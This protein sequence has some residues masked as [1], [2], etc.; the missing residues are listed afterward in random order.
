[1][2]L[3]Y[4]VYLLTIVYLMLSFDRLQSD[5]VVNVVK[6]QCDLRRRIAKQSKKRDDK[7]AWTLG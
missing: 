7:T 3:I 6:M 4:F 2:Y 5:I 1:M